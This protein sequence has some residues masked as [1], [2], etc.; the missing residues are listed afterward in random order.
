MNRSFRR[1]AKVLASLTAGLALLA[2][3]AGASA[4]F[5]PDVG[6]V[7][8]WWPLAEGGGQKINDW[9]GYGNHGFLGSTPQADAND[10]AWVRGIFNT[11][12]LNFGGDDFVTIP[13]TSSLNNPKFS[14]SLWV[15]APQ[16]P[17]TFKYLLEQGSK[18]CTSASF[19]LST[20][21]NGGLQ[22]YGWDGAN[23]VPSGG[24]QP[25]QIWD[26]KW[27]N[28]IA[29]YNGSSGRLWRGGKGFWGA[30]RSPPPP[31]HHH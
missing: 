2:M 1:T 7:K 20:G 15:R 10:P 3:P 8:A 4:G 24:A 5:L 12:E 16:S 30:P 29:T 21:N 25:E 22:Y 14:V 9:S 11:R 17:G 31:R 27:H 26:G 6:R 18:D 23:Q 13:G 28:V 19:G